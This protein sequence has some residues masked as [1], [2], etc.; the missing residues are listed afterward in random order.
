RS[1]HAR[2]G[3][4]KAVCADAEPRDQ[5]EVF[6]QA[7][8]VVAGHPPGVAVANDAFALAESIPYTFPAFIRGPFDLVSAG[9]H[10]PCEVLRELAVHGTICT[11]SRPS[12]RATATA[13]FP[14]RR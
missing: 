2:P 6:G 14:A 11:C 8:I 13:T 1:Q 9:C 4:R 12:F 3:Y 7:M 5:I 10:S